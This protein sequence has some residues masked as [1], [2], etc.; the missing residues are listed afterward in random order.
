L[1]RSKM[2]SVIGGAA[3]TGLAA[4]QADGGQRQT[5]WPSLGTSDPPPMPTELEPIAKPFAGQRNTAWPTVGNPDSPLASGT[6]LI[7]PTPSTSAES[8]PTLAHPTGVREK[9]SSTSD[10]NENPILGAYNNASSLTPGQP[11]TRE[12]S[13][14]AFSRFSAIRRPPP[15]LDIDAVRDAEARGSLTSLPDLIRRATRLAAM[16]DRGKRPGS[17]MN[18]LSDFPSD[19]DLSSRNK[20]CKC[21]I[22][23]LSTLL[24]SYSLT[25]W[26]P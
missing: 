14:S 23:I 25:R 12:R 22:G 24:T 15:R 16:M 6:G 11:K 1:Q 2:D 18:D 19:I 9:R 20:E 8:V 21:S 5:F 13:P 26:Q 3:T 10:P 17:R 4:S 7:D